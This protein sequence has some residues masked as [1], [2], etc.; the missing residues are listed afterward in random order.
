[1]LWNITSMRKSSKAY[2]ETMINSINKQHEMRVDFMNSID[3]LQELYEEEIH[4]L[5]T[6]EGLYDLRNNP[7]QYK[8]YL[9][10]LSDGRI[11]RGE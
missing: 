8:M 1:M 4:L 5:K 9:K 7:E 3:Q 6:N 11:N 10:L 2:G